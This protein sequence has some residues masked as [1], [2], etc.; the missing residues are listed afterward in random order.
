MTELASNLDSRILSETQSQAL[1]EEILDTIDAEPW[2]EAARLNLPAVQTFIRNGIH[3]INQLEIATHQRH[4]EIHSD[5]DVIYIDSGPGPYSFNMLQPGKADLEDV[6]YH[7]WPWSRKMDRA[8]IRAAY[9]IAELVTVMRIKEQTGLTKNTGDLTEDDFERYGP[10]LMY[11]SVAW[12]QSHIE[13]ALK[14][15][16]RSGMFKIPGSK[17]IGY[18]TFTNRAGVVQPIVHT[19]DQVEGFHFSPFVG[20]AVPRRMVIVSHPAHLLKIVHI[21]GKYPDSIPQGTTLQLFPVPTPISA[22]PEYS[23]AEIR[24]TLGSIFR[25][26]RATLEPFARYEI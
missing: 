13:H 1:Y 14:M 3:F 17:L 10:Y 21:L 4:P 20:K 11:T 12:Q 9:K 5:T 16:R 22:G 6:S 23:K 7:K 8:R 19:E 26:G 15:A 24:G 2:H 25:K 18:T